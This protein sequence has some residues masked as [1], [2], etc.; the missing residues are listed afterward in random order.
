V[1]LAVGKLKYLVHLS[2]SN[3]AAVI[4]TTDTLYYSLK[5]LGTYLQLTRPAV[6]RAPAAAADDDDSSVAAGKKK[7]QA[8]STPE[9]SYANR[10]N[11]TQNVGILNSEKLNFDGM[12][13]D[14]KLAANETK[15]S[16]LI[17]N[18]GAELDFLD[19]TLQSLTN[20]TELTYQLSARIHD[21]FIET[22]P[23]AVRGKEVTEASLNVPYV[24]LMR[25]YGDMISSV[26]ADAIAVTQKISTLKTEASQQ[27]KEW[28]KVFITN[29]DGCANNRAGAQS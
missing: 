15:V 19:R 7:R 16:V 9:K 22:E 17:N 24:N 8:D 4:K 29:F 5:N 18:F 14:L 27:K 13:A 12:T 1:D 23:K 6:T 26:E 2:E 3:D 20:C 28:M 21:A 25:S 11:K 10:S